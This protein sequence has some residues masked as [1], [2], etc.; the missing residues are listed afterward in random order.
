MQSFEI[1]RRMKFNK[2]TKERGDQ[3]LRGSNM[4]RLRFRDT[5]G[6]GGGAEFNRPNDREKH[7]SKKKQVKGET[8]RS[9]R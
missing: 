1:R 7:A 8:N 9:K 2:K 5:R 6:R 3:V 4:Y